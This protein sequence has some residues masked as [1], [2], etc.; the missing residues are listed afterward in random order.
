MDEDGPDQPGPAGAADPFL[1]RVLAEY[2]VLTAGLGDVERRR[3]LRHSWIDEDG[4]VHVR[5]LRV[6]EGG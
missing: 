5:R 2:E 4:G 3:L 6:V 1:A